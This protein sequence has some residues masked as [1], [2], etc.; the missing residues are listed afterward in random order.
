[1][2]STPSTPTGVD[3]SGVINSV[4]TAVSNVLTG[5]AEA[6]A[7]NANLIATALIGIGIAYGLYRAALPLMRNLLTFIRGAF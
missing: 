7:N 6:I 3:W 4:L 1:M 5:V 2:S